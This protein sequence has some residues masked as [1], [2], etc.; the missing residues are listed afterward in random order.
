MAKARP[1]KSGRSPLPWV[2]VVLFLVSWLVPGF[3]GQQL[4]GSMG[5]M[6]KAL[7]VGHE[8][9]VAPLSGPDWLPGWA[10]CHFAWSALT[11][12]H[13]QSHDDWK[14]I[15]VGATCLTNIT[16]VLTL[17]AMACGSRPRVLGLLLL[18]CAALDASWLYLGGA[19]MIRTLRAEDGTA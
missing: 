14:R 3:Q 1:S 4:F 9:T 16:M 5:G 12:Q 10:A 19:D 11:D 15:V 7:G 18:G 13:S 17:V 2:G 6:A 8:P